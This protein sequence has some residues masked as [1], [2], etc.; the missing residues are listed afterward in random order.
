M[1]PE[2][3]AVLLT[4]AP[5]S[6]ELIY[7]ASPGRGYGDI[8]DTHSKPLSPC[9][10]QPR[11]LS[12]KCQK[13]LR[14]LPEHLGTERQGQQACTAFPRPVSSEGAALV[15]S[16]W[17]TTGQ[18]VS[19]AGRSRV[20]EPMAGEVVR[21]ADPPRGAAGRVFCSRYSSHDL[22]GAACL[23]WKGRNNGGRGSAL[24]VG[25]GMAALSPRVLEDSAGLLSVHTGV[26][27]EPQRLLDD[28]L[29]DLVELLSVVPPHLGSVYVGSTLIVGL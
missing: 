26:A 29:G 21:T 3:A 2:K 25:V 9:Q 24:P 12:A 11:L 22:R 19:T 16:P 17:Q 18:V 15:S 1:Q 23:G 5:S 4:R 27:S 28:L 6:H 20:E 13:K 7:K 10:R 8:C 14:M